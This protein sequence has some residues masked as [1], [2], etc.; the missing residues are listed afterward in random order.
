MK[1]GIMQPYFLP[2]LGYWQL[3]NAVDRYVIYD[4]VNYIKGGRINRNAILVNN[5]A[6]NINLLLCK[7][8]PNRHINEITLLNDEISRNKLLKTFEMA[9]HKAPFWLDVKPII[10]EIF[11]FP[12]LNLAHFLKNSFEIIG[13]YLGITTQLILSSSIEKDNEL[14]GEWKVYEICKK[15]NATEYYNSIGGFELYSKEKFIE[16]GIKLSF[17]KMKSIQYRQ[18]NDGFVPNLSIIDVMMFNS[19]EQIKNLMMEYEL[20]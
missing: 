4:D 20:L 11:E 8:S 7:A 17:L 5:S 1:I 9:Y 13:Q 15:L 19:K 14:K 16:Q 2:Y 3:M 18:F 12:N 6:Q 10:N